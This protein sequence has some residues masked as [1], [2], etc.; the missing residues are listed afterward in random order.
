MENRKEL[1]KKLGQIQAEGISVG[2]NGRN[3]F[4]KYDYV[5]EA[6]VVEAI[7]KLFTKHNLLLLADTLDVNTV[8]NGEKTLYTRV[9]VKYTIIDVD[10]GQSLEQVFYGDG[11][12]NSDKG[13]YKAYTGSLKYFLMKTFRIATGDDPERDEAA[14][15]QKK[16]TP[17]TTTSTVTAPP[18]STPP[19]K[20]GFSK[21][22]VPVAPKTNNG[23]GSELWD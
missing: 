7:D 20:S 17:V 8:T 6:D 15:E 1:Y 23:S 21:P 10:T 2:K 11:A 9:K 12:D 3:E 18:I 5:T 4:H 16:S 19:R 14:S 22:G 13:I